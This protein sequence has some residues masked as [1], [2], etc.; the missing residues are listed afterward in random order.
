MENKFNKSLELL[1]NYLE[2]VSDE[3]FQEDWDTVSSM[4]SNYG[5]VPVRDYLQVYNNTMEELLP[6]IPES[7]RK[8]SGKVFYSGRN[9]F[10]GKKKIYVL[11]INPGGDPIKQSN[12]TV[13]WHTDLVL[14]MKTP[15]WSSYINES[16]RGKAPGEYRFQKRILYLFG[17]LNLNAY[18][19]PS[20][21]TI[22]LRTR[23]AEDIKDNSLADTCWKF[24]EKVIE[25]LGVQVVLCLGNDAGK[26]VCNKT[27]ANDLIG[28][29]K[30]KNNRK[31]AT[32]AFTNKEGFLVFVVTHP[33]IAD[34]TNPTQDPTPFIK[35]ILQER[36]II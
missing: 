14:S 31:W 10:T 22:F 23:R 21:N 30:E 32:K 18:E 3:Q 7:L 27:N 24:H 28:V 26:I 12:E 20:S 4:S 35:K 5:V 1:D 29:F 8:K 19:V 17:G 15:N 33:S 13:E 34:W 25:K 16:W 9:A 36:N 11:G 2:N 6:L